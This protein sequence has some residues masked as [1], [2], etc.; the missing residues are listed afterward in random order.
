MNNHI[1]TLSVTLK[2]PCKDGIDWFKERMLRYALD[3]VPFTSN[4]NLSAVDLGEED[5]DDG[6]KID[7]AEPTCD[8]TD[9]LESSCQHE[10]DSMPLLKNN[11][12]EAFLILTVGYS[13]DATSARGMVAAFSESG[14][15]KGS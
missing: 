11:R 4:I 15:L 8:R 10:D 12:D 7:G 1:V 5:P 3:L 2:D 6:E 13:I 9:H 14:I